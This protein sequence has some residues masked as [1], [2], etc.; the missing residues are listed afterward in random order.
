MLS[1]QITLG[2]VTGED[3]EQR[4]RSAARTRNVSPALRPILQRVDVSLD[5][6]AQ[7]GTALEELFTFLSM[8]AGRTD[9]NCCTT[10]RYFSAL[11]E[12]GRLEVVDEPLLGIVTSIGGTLHDTIYA[13]HIA[14]NFDSLPEQFLER[15]RKA[16]HRH[17][18]ER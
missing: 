9:A 2:D 12:D 14:R 7:L 15:V 4:F 16:L 1:L 17:P 3:F 11:E 6:P 8:P 13:P 10:D 18:D 5:D